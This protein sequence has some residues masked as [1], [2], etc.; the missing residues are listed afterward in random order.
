MW[1]ASNCEEVARVVSL[2]QLQPFDLVL[3]SSCGARLGVQGLL[4]ALHSPLIATLLQ[5]GGR[6]GGLSLPMPLPTVRGVLAYMQ[7]QGGLEDEEEVGEAAH[8]MGISWKSPQKMSYD[9]LNPNFIPKS[10]NPT[11]VSALSND[12]TDLQMR[13]KEESPIFNEYESVIKPLEGKEQQKDQ[14]QKGLHE[15]DSLVYSEE[16]ILDVFETRRGRPR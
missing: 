3:V 11:K 4:L 1:G 16:Q 15:E 13:A 5:Q 10:L 2:V 7:G 8:L 6:E 12:E 14:Q 9:R